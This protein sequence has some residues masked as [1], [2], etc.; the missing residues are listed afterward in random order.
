[1]LEVRRLWA[2]GTILFL[3]A[4]LAS[5]QVWGEP[6]RD[7]DKDK[8]LKDWRKGKDGKDDKD[9]AADRR[10]AEEMGKSR[11]LGKPLVLYPRP[12]GEVLFAWQAQPK[13]DDTPARPRDYVV[14][15]TTSASMAQG[16]LNDAIKITESLAAK[17]NPKDRMAVW[18]VNT[19][20]RSLTRGFKTGKALNDAVKSLEKEFPAGAVN[21]KQALNEVLES[22]D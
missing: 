21:L 16:P 18:T 15:V 12:N 2:V 8:E 17:L 6:A 1:M 20:P 14:L 7:K 13:L 5:S 11:F 3:S 22:Y 9:D 4:I 10:F 19:K